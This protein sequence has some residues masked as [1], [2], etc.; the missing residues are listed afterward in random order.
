MHIIDQHA[1]QERINYELYK[2]KLGE[3]SKEI[4][5]VLVPIKLE[6]T[7]SEFLELKEKQDIINRVGIFFEEFGQNSVIIR[8]HPR[9]LN[10][11]F[12]TDQIR[13]ILE[14]IISENDF[15]KEKFNEKVAITLACKMS[16]KAND[17]I[18]LEEADKL[19]ETLLK[20]ENPYTC[21]HGRPTIINYSYYELEKLFKRAM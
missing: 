7:S 17:Y 13:K 18:S 12:T 11:K 4:T 10:P 6:F 1:A 8:K 21:P 5:D 20:C 14:I 9:W 16:I 3:E 19:L 2:K 15:S